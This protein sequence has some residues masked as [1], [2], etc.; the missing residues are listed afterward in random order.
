MLVLMRV[1]RLSFAIAWLVACLLSGCD[2]GDAIY[3]V[4]GTITFGSEPVSQGTVTFEE[5]GTMN[6]TQAPLTADG[7]YSL[8]LAAGNYKIMV[9]PPLVAETG[10]SDASTTYKAVKNI[11]EKFRSSHSTTLT[12]RIVGRKTLD[13]NLK[14]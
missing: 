2:S 12:A 9:E 8:R 14:S 10:V 1:S 5:T 13:F 11:P 4:Q 7:K 6:S 3:N